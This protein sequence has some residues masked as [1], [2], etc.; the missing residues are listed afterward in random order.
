MSAAAWAL[1]GLDPRTASRLDHA[2]SGLHASTGF[3]EHEILA[4]I[5]HAGLENQDAVQARLAESHLEAVISALPADPRPVPD[6]S[7][8][9]QLLTRRIPQA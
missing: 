7:V 2:V 9:D 8:Y 6:V 4:A 3:P 5:I 1:P